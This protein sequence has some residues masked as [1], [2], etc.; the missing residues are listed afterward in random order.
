MR[1]VFRNQAKMFTLYDDN[2]HYVLSV[3]CG[4]VGMYDVNVPLDSEECAS[5]REEGEAFLET[6]AYKIARDPNRYRDR[7]TS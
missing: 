4:G 2:G 7:R 1:E 5:Y 3:V 6:L